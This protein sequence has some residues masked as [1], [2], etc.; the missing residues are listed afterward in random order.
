MLLYKWTRQFSVA[1]RLRAG[2]ALSVAGVMLVACALLWSG[3]RQQ[4]ADRELA[5]RQA[6]EVAH[7]LVSW[8]HGQLL[9]GKVDEATAQAMALGA[10]DKV[11]YSGQEYF[12]V[13]DMQAKMVH[14]PIKPKLDGQSMQDTKDPQGVFLFREFVKTASSAD[15]AGF[16]SYQWP[17]PG[18]DQ[19]QD[20][21]SYVKAFTPWGWIIGSG[22]YVDDLQAAL[23]DKLTQVLGLVLTVAAL[24]WLVIEFTA[25]DLNEGV[26]MALSR[27]ES[28]A[29]GD[30]A[31]GL[32]PHP[33]MA[34]R[35]EIARM[36]R[37]M[38]RMAQG[39]STTVG[40]V[41]RSVD[42][43][44]MASQQ[45]A[46]GNT[47]LSARTEQAASS[48]QQTAS[49]MD[50]LAQTVSHNADASTHALSRANQAAQQAQRGGAV[51]SQVVDTM[52]EIHAS[53]RKIAD[54]IGVIDSIAFQTN[55][56][57]L[58]AA[59]EAARAGEQGR[60]FAVVAG[61]VRQ[62]AQ[63]SANAAR[64]IKNLILSSTEQVESGASL[65]QD[66][67]E[68]M[69]AMVASVDQLSDLVHQIANSTA[70][71]SQ[72]VGQVHSAVS[73][74]DQMTSQNAALVEES[75]AAAGSLRDQATALAH[76][77]NRF[78]LDAE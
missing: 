59:V 22:L 43:V 60:G 3:Y 38:H 19:P 73:E 26:R 45:I 65:V 5:V 46:A 14:H 35:D 36:L 68:T 29:Q 49:S 42:S 15:A 33:R 23:R 74:L 11:R 34:D 64:E 77:V 32:Q 62:L 12:W 66:A 9:S 6:V 76:V 16:V 18:S 25:R 70:A 8:A 24:M 63:R 47:D 20:K 61:E 40:E 51:V 55:I 48:L 58:N 52:A 41:Q 2:G 54:I 28:I 10:L 37:A 1:T 50:A 17:K 21:V 13:N 69:R 30:L 39:L 27:A 44:A 72:G 7:G 53:A 78:K 31:G 75:A 67:G 57:A 4:L 71:Q 56:L